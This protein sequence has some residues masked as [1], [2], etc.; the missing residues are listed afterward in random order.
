MKKYTY[1]DERVEPNKVLFA[2]AAETI[3]DADE[4]FKEIMNLNPLQTG[5]ATKI[6]DIKNETDGN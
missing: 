1:I 2:I 5:I 6:E 3:A 4:K